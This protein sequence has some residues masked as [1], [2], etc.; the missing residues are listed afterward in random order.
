MA[1][2]VNAPQLY[3]VPCACGKT[4]SVRARQAGDQ[5]TCSCGAVVNVPTIR[6]LKQLKTVVDETELPAQRSTWQ[7]P[8]FSIGLIALF[9]GAMI[10]LVAWLFP[11]AYLHA[12]WQTAALNA[13][14]AERANQVVAEMGVS[15]LYDEFLMLRD[16]TRSTPWDDMRKQV[17]T[18][19]ATQRNRHLAGGIFLG[20]GALLTIV[21]LALPAVSG[22]S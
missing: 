4:V 1:T 8:L 9:I 3:L 2:E 14:D 19:Q 21:G 17:E 12:D 13:A 15:D 18:A 10:F 6:G 22:K 7:G 11:P 5:V 20:L 16:R